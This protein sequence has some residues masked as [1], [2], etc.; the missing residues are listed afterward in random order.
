MEC[1]SSIVDVLSVRVQRLLVLNELSLAHLGGLTLLDQFKFGCA[2][3]V[4]TLIRTR[5]VGVGSPVVQLL[6]VVQRHFL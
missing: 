4:Q 2:V 5:E 1:L 3:V 6:N